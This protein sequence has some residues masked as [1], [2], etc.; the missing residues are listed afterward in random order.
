ML[1]VNHLPPRLIIFKVNF[2]HGPVVTWSNF[3][4]MALLCHGHVPWTIDQSL[5]SIGPYQANQGNLYKYREKGIEG[6]I[7]VK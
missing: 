5:Q 1:S 4:S 3:F 6:D 2:G 7:I